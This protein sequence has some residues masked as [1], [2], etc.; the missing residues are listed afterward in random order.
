MNTQNISKY[1]GSK[2]DVIL[3][4]SEFFDF[5]LVNTEEEYFGKSI[6]VVLD[7]S[8]LYDFELVIISDEL[9]QNFIDLVLDYSEFF[10][11]ELSVIMD[12]FDEDL[13]VES[14]RINCIDN[15][16]E[17]VTNGLQTEDLFYILTEDNNVILY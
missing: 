15:V 11:Y 1:Y 13:V 8:E 5:V 7:K 9:N 14:T 17:I 3:D 10:D 2:L 4:N 16:V 6:D 12:D